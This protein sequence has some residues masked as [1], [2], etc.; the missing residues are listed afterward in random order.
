MKLVAVVA[1]VASLAFGALAG[2]AFAQSS[3]TE[4]AYGIQQG[5]DQ[6]STGGSSDNGGTT[7]ASSGSL[8]FT[9]LEV[10][11][12]ALIGAG[13]VGTGVVVRRLS[14]SSDPMGA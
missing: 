4:D 9:G 11:L 3:P 6:G 1:I 2:S 7:Q 5:I 12:L 10:G 13:L 8:P 14:R